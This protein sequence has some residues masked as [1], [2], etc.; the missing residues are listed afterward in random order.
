MRPYDTNLFD[1][2]DN[3]FLRAQQLLYLNSQNENKRKKPKKRTDFDENN[4][5]DM[6]R[7][8][9]LE[10]Q[11]QS[12]TKRAISTTALIAISI[13][14]GCSI[15]LQHTKESKYA[16]KILVG[17][18]LIWKEEDRIISVEEYIEKSKYFT[19]KMYCIIE[20]SKKNHLT[21]VEINYDMFDDF[22]TTFPFQYICDYN[23]NYD[24]E[25]VRKKMRS[26]NKEA[27]FSNYLAWYLIQRGVVL[28]TKVSGLKL[29]Q[30]AMH[31]FVWNYAILPDGKKILFD[32]EKDDLCSF[33]R[34][35]N[36]ILQRENI[37]NLNINH[38]SE[39]QKQK[40]KTTF[41]TTRKLSAF[42]KSD[43]LTEVIDCS[44][45][46]EVN[47]NGDEKQIPKHPFHNC[48]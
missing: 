17:E 39:E 13:C 43:T 11:S 8:Q 44:I 2:R 1:I 29:T 6:K 4:E 25:S 21:T 23:N 42:K 24:E 10:E 28:S 40:Y 20:K 27:A 22:N 48:N 15:K 37:L 47:S 35:I 16:L 31:C 33:V 3:Y 34:E 46:T 26:K 41:I 36:K 30:K 19:Q 9:Q 5:T 14:N 45:Q 32:T 18:E 7:I 38:L 12:R